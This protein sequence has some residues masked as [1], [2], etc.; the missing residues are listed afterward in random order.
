MSKYRVFF[1]TIFSEHFCHFFNWQN[2]H[3]FIQFYW[4]RPKTELK[5]K[6]LNKKTEYL[7]NH[8]DI[9]P[10]NLPER[11]NTGEFTTVMKNNLARI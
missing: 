3:R 9:R 4:N 7:P 11:T 5:K 10:S 6:N 2:T 1:K 8:P